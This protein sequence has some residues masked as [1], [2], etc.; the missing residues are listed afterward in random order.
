MP[1]DLRARASR[2]RHLM[3]QYPARATGLCS[4]KTTAGW[5]PTE[6]HVLLSVSS[7]HHTPRQPPAVARR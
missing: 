4:D 6:A 3:T 1:I 7:C 5:P 2:W